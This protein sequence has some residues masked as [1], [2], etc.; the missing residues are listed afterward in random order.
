M[1]YKEVLQQIV[2]DISLA[3]K[4]FPE[5]T[6][7]YIGKADN[8]EETIKRHEDQEDLNYTTFLAKGS[9]AIIAKLETDLIYYFKKSEIPVLNDKIGSPGNPNANMVYVCF[10][11]SVPDDIDG[12][13]GLQLTYDNQI[14]I[15]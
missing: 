13:I 5:G 8:K 3:Y 4:A 15:D 7:I 14:Q 9:P 2:N 6:K 1:K 10:D 12:E 11:N